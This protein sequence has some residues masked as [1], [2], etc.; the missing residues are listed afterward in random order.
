M[1]HPFPSMRAAVFAV[2]VFLLVLGVGM[3]SGRAGAQEVFTVTD[4]RVDATAETAAAARETALAEGQ[5][6][7]LGRLLERLTLRADHARLPALE[8]SQIAALVRN[9]EVEEEKTSP[10]RYLARLTVRFKP[11][12]VRGL[13]RSHGV[14]FAETLSK[15]VLVLPV[16]D[17]AGAL[18]LWDDRNPWRTAWARQPKRDGLVP[19]V[20]PLG[21][22]ADIADIGA[23]QAVRGDDARIAAIARRYGAADALVALARL[24]TVPLTNLPVLEV[25]VSRFGAV[26]Q[27]ETIVETFTAASPEGSEELLARAAEAVAVAVEE[28]WKRD[29][30]LRFDREGELAVAV[31]IEGLEDWLEVKRRLERVA[32]IRRSDLVYLSRGEARARLRFIGEQEQLTLALAQSDLVLSRGATSW[33]LRLGSPERNSV[34]Q[35]SAVGR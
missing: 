22:L 17:M 26:A 30:L 27:E 32:F 23:E 4:V 13:L 14:P 6:R 16:Y 33:I 7:A 29:N 1:V 19:L 18:A 20:A 21:D 35:P 10:V 12:A 15:P 31:P 34:V 3:F 25:S 2:A 28:N 11:G 8:P 24:R 9:F 5:R